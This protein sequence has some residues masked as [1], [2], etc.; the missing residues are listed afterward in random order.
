MHYI[1]TY[2]SEKDILAFYCITLTGTENNILSMYTKVFQA[3]STYG[4]HK[5]AALVSITMLKRE[6]KKG[7]STLRLPCLTPQWQGEHVTDVKL[8][9][10]TS[11]VQDRLTDS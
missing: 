2:I 4:L 6:R 7:R 3:H 9:V 10:F 11:I 5:T 8:C 1:H